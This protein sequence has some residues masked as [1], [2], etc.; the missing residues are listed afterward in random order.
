MGICDLVNFD[1]QHRRAEIG[2]VIQ[3]SFR[4]CGYAQATLISL[5]KYASRVLHLHQLYA[6]ID[7]QNQSA[8]SL[9]LMMG[10]M[11]TSTLPEWLYDGSQYHEAVVMQKVL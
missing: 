5:H 2:M 6:I 11:Q 10:Y 9:F 4:H 3:K 7:I 1:P 8:I